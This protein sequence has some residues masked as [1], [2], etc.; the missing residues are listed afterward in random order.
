M[1]VTTLSRFERGN[2]H[3]LSICTVGRVFP[4]TAIHN[5]G[6]L[7]SILAFDDAEELTVFWLERRWS[8]DGSA[9]L[10]DA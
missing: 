5:G 2:D 8:S 10:V 1:N 4:A 6:G 7:A 9:L 3:Y